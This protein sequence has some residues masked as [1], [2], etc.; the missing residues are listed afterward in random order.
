MDSV[1]FA[2]CAGVASTTRPARKQKRQ[3]DG[4]APLI[5]PGPL[6]LVGQQLLEKT[7]DV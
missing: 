6:A 4:S 1:C 5:V 3:L 7:E 2:E